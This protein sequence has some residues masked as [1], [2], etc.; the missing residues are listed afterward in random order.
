MDVKKY[1]VV[2]SQ[3]QFSEE[4]YIDI[5]PDNGVIHDQIFF[6]RIQLHKQI[7]NQPLSRLYGS[8]YLN[9]NNGNITVEFPAPQAKKDSPDYEAIKKQYDALEP[10]IVR[11]YQQMVASGQETTLFVYSINQMFE[12]SESKNAEVESFA[13]KRRA[14]MREVEEKTSKYSEKHALELKH[15]FPQTLQEE[16]RLRQEKLFEDA[17]ERRIY[18]EHKRAGETAPA[19]LRFQKLYSGD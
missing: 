14:K 6:S 8:I 2:C 5:A 4:V 16:Q 13:R 10:K 19:W 9:D 11:R 12:L 15:E 7:D 17:K 3:A 18:S 1:R